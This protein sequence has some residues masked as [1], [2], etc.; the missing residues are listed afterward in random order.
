MALTVHIGILPVG[1][2]ARI[3]GFYNRVREMIWDD[4]WQS[5][6]AY[7]VL[8]EP[9]PEFAEYD[10]PVLDLE[11]AQRLMSRRLGIPLRLLFPPPPPEKLPRCERP[12]CG[13]KTR[14]GTPC[15]AP[16]VWDEVKGY[17]ARC[18]MHGGLSTGPKTLAGRAR[19]SAAQQRRWKRYR[20][21]PTA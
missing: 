2:R 4:D 5:E 21:D 17:N 11:A 3:M 9:E 18:R 6:L 19:I 15:K 8:V 10:F 1:P 14:Q 7:Q 20:A 13:A 16:C 12:R